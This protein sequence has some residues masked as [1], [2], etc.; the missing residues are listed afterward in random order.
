MGAVQDR[1]EESKQGSRKPRTREGWTRD[2]WDKGGVNQDRGHRI[3]LNQRDNG[4][5]WWT[6]RFKGTRGSEVTS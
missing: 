6:R 4:T 2:I 5:G 3:R 1:R